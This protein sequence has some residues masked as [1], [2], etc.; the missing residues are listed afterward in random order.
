MEIDLDNMSK[1]ELLA[2]KAKV[3]K[4]LETVEARRKA[5][6]LK[7]LE[8]KA[9]EFGYPLNELLAGPAKGAKA[10]K[11]VPKYRNPADPSQTWTG[12]GRKPQWVNDALAKG[13][14]ME[15]LEI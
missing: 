15:D 8:D 14:P 12:R 7:A 13:T 11:G 3:D 10:T 5:E 2:L 6:A 9:R 4:A 1:D